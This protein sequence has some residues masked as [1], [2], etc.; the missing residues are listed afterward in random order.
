MVEQRTREVW[1]DYVKVLACSLVVLGH[2]FQSMTEAQILPKTDLY[3]WFIQTIYMFHVPLFFICSGYLYQSYSCV[4]SL[5]SWG[6]NVLKKFLAL[7]IPYFA[8]STLTWILKTVFS[9]SVNNEIEMGLFE[10]LFLSPT[11][12]YWYLYALFF[13]F[14]ITPTF[15]NK[16]ATYIGLSI[17]V[18]FK[19]ILIFVGGF[20]I[21]IISYVLSNEFWFVVGMFISVM[22]FPSFAKQNRYLVIGLLGFVL[23]L[24]LSIL[25]YILNIVINGIEFLLGIVACLSIVLIFI[26]LFADNGTNRVLGFFARYT[27]PVFLMHT[28]F[29]APF[30][31]L[32]IKIGITNA[33]VHVVLGIT[34]SFA[35]PII[36]GKIAK[37]SKYLE[38][39]F[40]P[41]KFIRIKN[42][43]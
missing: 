10:T 31:V 36:V 40:Y 8:F 16:K 15:K 34:I 28:L 12:P 3:N 35:G 30:R 25:I 38:I 2:F 29:A 6:K 19:L 20:G 32:L 24:L 23:F 41:T 14:L 43:S 21:Q 26:K 22:K 5:Q 42:R 13:V 18:A 27:M 33:I 7:G 4:D 37:V 17:A 11:A 9:S 1:V 39:F